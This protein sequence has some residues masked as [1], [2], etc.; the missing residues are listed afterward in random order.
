[1]HCACQHIR[2]HSDSWFH[3]DYWWLWEAGRQTNIFSSCLKGYTSHHIAISIWLI[4]LQSLT[5]WEQQ[6]DEGPAGVLLSP[7]YPWCNLGLMDIRGA[8][9][10][11][12]IR[13]RIGSHHPPPSA[14]TIGLHQL[15]SPAPFRPTTFDSWHRI[16][17]SWNQGNDNCP[18]L[19]WNQ[20]KHPPTI[21]FLCLF[22]FS[23]SM[24]VYRRKLWDDQ[25]SRTEV[26]EGNW[27]GVQPG[28]TNDPIVVGGGMG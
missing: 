3:N 17:V 27:G 15:H 13:S 22:V 8:P 10:L 14:S 6:L 11:M 9:A 18:L 23:C 21:F 19:H 1:M 28:H 7:Y 20:S 16:C 26:Q 25:G 2:Y 5:G 4:P 24:F 12:D